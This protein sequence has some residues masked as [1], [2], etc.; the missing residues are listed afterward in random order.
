MTKKGKIAN[1]FAVTTLNSYH[2]FDGQNSHNIYN[3]LRLITLD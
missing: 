1:K 2:G 3:D